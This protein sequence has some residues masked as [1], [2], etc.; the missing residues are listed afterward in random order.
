MNHSHLVELFLESAWHLHGPVY[1]RLSG[2]LHNHINGTKAPSES[3]DNKLLK[4]NPADENIDTDTQRA[5]EDRKALDKAY[6]DRDIENNI[7]Y[8]ESLRDEREAKN[9]YLDTESGIAVITIRGVLAKHSDQVNGACMPQ[10]RSYAQI[11]QQMNTAVAAGAKAI[12]LRTETPGG[13]AIG[14]QELNDTIRT[15]SASGVPVHGFVDGYCYSAGTYSLSACDTITLSSH[16]AGYGSIGT[17]MSTYDDSAAWAQAGLEAVIIRSGTYKALGQPGEKISDLARSEM[18]R[19]CDAFATAFYDAVQA[20]RGLTDEQCAAVC[21]G[22]LFTAVESIELGLA[23]NIQSWDDFISDL[24]THVATQSHP[25]K[26]E[27]KEE[28]MSVFKK[29][30]TAASASK[31][32]LNK[33]EFSALVKQFPDALNRIEALDAE[34]NDAS[35][36]KMIL[37]EEKI[38]ALEAAPVVDA[39]TD[40]DVSAKTAL[41]TATE[42]EA[43]AAASAYAEKISALEAKVES[44]TTA[45]A[46]LSDWKSGVTET[47][48]PGGDEASLGAENSDTRLKSEWAAMSPAEQMNFGG[49]FG[50]FAHAKKS[51]DLD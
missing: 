13:M 5:G 21:N 10:G 17:V 29:K 20:G 43:A 12:V 27:S 49:I 22:R 28:I 41:E 38:A 42:V 45:Q 44:L 3:F 19:T 26:P 1:S 24:S 18:Q 32:G 33:T 25:P 9:D 11:A 2:L 40:T 31:D 48:D 34:N 14:C 46:K 47:A 35:T 23:D 8:E 37:L 51:G 7:Y 36:I 6:I 50:A 16:A 39:E 15:I 30:E 4:V